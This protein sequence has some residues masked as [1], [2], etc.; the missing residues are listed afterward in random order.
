MN[1]IELK[2]AI[3]A[4]ILRTDDID[5]LE[6]V[7]DLLSQTKMEEEWY[8]DFEQNMTPEAKADLADSIAQANDPNQIISNEEAVKMLRALPTHD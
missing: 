6:E 7:L 3:L 5:L 2:E 4:R 8:D 1:Q